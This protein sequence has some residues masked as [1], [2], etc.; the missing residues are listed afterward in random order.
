MLPAPDLAVVLAV[1]LPWLEVTAA[2]TLFV[3]RRLGATT[4]R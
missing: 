3:K 1:Y 4:R 2:L